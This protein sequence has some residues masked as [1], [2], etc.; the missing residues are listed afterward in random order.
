MDKIEEQVVT[1]EKVED[2]RTHSRAFGPAPDN[3]NPTKTKLERRL[4]WKIDL[5]ILPLAALIYFVAY[6]VCYNITLCSQN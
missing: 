3:V 4:L 6:L 1:L 5:I 2:I